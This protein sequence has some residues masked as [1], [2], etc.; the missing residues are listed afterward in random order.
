DGS[1]R[2][3]QPA[4]VRQRMGAT[5]IAVVYNRPSAR[6]REL[7]GGLVPYDSIWN[8]GADEA[9]RIE[10]SEDV[11]VN[12]ERLPAGKYSIWAIPRPEEW[13]LIFSRAH[14]VFHIPYPGEDQDALRLEVRPVPAPHMETM[15][16]T[17]PVATR[18]SAVLHF[19]WGQA[20]ISF[21]LRPAR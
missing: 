4:E 9:T 5:E 15:A 2:G 7:F 20:L 14:D 6:G 18:D 21:R 17:F 8:P 13:T 19:R 11:T 1:D 16:F 10:L 12:G 3:S